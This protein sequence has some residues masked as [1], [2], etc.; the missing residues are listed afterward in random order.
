[1]YMAKQNLYTQSQFLF[2]SSYI[3]S[4]MPERRF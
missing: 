1:M 4:F 2:M 3:N